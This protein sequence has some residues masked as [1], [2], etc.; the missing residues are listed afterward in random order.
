[1]D[2]NERDKERA[3]QIS[4]GMKKF[5]EFIVARQEQIK[6]AR[7]AL[8]NA[9]NLALGK[10]KTIVRDDRTGEYVQIYVESADVQGLTFL[11]I[12]QAKEA[13]PDAIA[14]NG[15]DVARLTFANDL[16]LEYMDNADGD[17][18]LPED[19]NKARRNILR[20]FMESFDGLANVQ[21]T[22]DVKTFRDFAADIRM[23]NA[24]FARMVEKV[25]KQPLAQLEVEQ[26]ARI[27]PQQPED[28]D[29]YEQF[30]PPD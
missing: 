26:D 11:A 21:I 7:K 4:D 27:G 8:F 28:N 13:V 20:L 22:A 17:R 2:A 23:S 18:N 12:Q 14:D 6:K 1:M 9:L 15:P 5:H 24:H 25:M 16:L 30:V 29:D 3:L 19:L 10:K